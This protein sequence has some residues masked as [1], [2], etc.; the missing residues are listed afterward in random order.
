MKLGKF[1]ADSFT[2]PIDNEK[3]FALFG[4]VTAFWAF[5]YAFLHASFDPQMSNKYQIL[6]ASL[7]SC[8]FVI[9]RL[10]L[11]AIAQGKSKY[12]IVEPDKGGVSLVEH[13]KAAKKSIRATHFTPE[14]Q[15]EGYVGIL[16]DKLREGV[17]IHRLVYY[18]PQAKAGAYDWLGR[19]S[20]FPD[21]Y[22][23][24]KT[25]VCLPY[26]VVVIDRHL[27][28]M[29]FPMEHHDFYNKAVWFDD[30]ELGDLF[31][32][33]F[34]TFVTAHATLE[35]VAPKKVATAS[36]RPETPQRAGTT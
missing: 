3:A 24:F 30:K 15:S 23:Q 32:S 29:F 19:F 12:H 11:S 13:V 22:K 35:A 18:V 21:H 17:K 27:V 20:E 16:I 28:W 7:L 26:N 10:L 31:A 33:A 5:A 14:P 6:L 9:F 2:E 8:F 36:E 25:D 1:I 34:D 4:Q